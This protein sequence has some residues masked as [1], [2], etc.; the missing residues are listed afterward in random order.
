MSGQ[1]VSLRAESLVRRRRKTEFE[2]NVPHVEVPR[3]SNACPPRTVW[4]SKT[5]LL[6]IL[7]LLERPDEGRVLFDGRPVDK[8]DCDI[9]LQMAAVFQRPYLFKGSVTANVEYG[10]AARR[11][12]ASERRKRVA[13]LSSVSVS[14]A[15]NS[16]ARWPYPAAK[17]R[18][19]L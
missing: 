7:G 15:T 3:W 5:T 13:K 14:Q 8:S 12:P 1:G 6:E 9:R 16:A 2:L 4:L 19:C 17:R 18:G 10:L 11:I